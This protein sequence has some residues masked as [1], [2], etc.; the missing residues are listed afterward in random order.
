MRRD[1]DSDI[2]SRVRDLVIEY[3]KKKY[4]EDS[5]CCILT[6]G[7]QQPKAAIRNA[8][9]LLGSEKYDDKTRYADL[10][11]KIAKDVPKTVGMTFDKPIS[12]ETKETCFEMLKRTYGENA[13][14]NTILDYAKDMELRIQN[15]GMHA[16]GVIISDGNPVS[17]YVPLM[18]NTKKQRWV[19]QCDMV[20]SEEKG[21][22]KMD[23]LGLKNL[24]IITDTLRYI[25][26]DYGYSLDPLKIPITDKKTFDL[27]SSGITNGVFQFES[28][29]MKE[30]LKQFRPDCIEDLILLVAAYRPGPMQYLSKIIKVK[31]G[32]EKINYLT[33]ELKPILDKTYGSIIYQEQ[34]MQIFQ[35]LAGYSLGQADLV[36]R[37]MSKKKFK[38]LEKERASFINGDPERKIKGCKANG[39][40]EEIA[41]SLFDEMIEFAK[42]AFNKSHAA[43]YAFVAYITAYFKAN[44]PC[45]YL[46]ADMNW[47]NIDKIPG[48]MMDC[49]KF[50]IEVLPPNINESVEDFSIHNNSILFGLKAV[51][52]V[53]NSSADIIRVRKEHGKFTS[54]KEFI[55]VTNCN[56]EVLESLI[57]AGAFDIF[58]SNRYAM[59]KII[60]A[61]KKQTKTIKE[62]TELLEELK[63]ELA[64]VSTEKDRKKI[65]TREK[66]AEKSL[67]AA[68]DA[69]IST[70]VPTLMENQKER[71]KRE[72]ELIGVYVSAHPLD[73][74]ASPTTLKCTPI[75]ELTAGKKKHI[76]GLVTNLSI[77]PR[78]SDGAPMA[79]FDLEDQT[80]TIPVTCFTKAYANFGEYVQE[81]AVIKINGTCIEEESFR[82]DEDE[83]VMKFNVESI[84]DVKPIEKTVCIYV[85]DMIDWTE[86]TS[87][88]VEKYATPEGL[89]VVVYDKMLSEFR[90]T[91]LHV[92]HEILSNKVGISAKMI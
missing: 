30:M 44:Y 65:L 6:K 10:G 56:K 60:E 67:A 32:K 28:G 37:A 39:I 13:T 63:V 16:A 31:Q 68:E 64:K 33:P 69:Y 4:G 75:E 48:L 70:Q 61:T 46:C 45:E 36:R 89:V 83:M 9:R 71:L 1:I 25:K 66:N 79:F 20:Q 8:A 80:G 53:G 82:D 90:K 88:L 26:K 74:Y 81:D 92:T 22:L 34:V 85:N 58:G 50:N 12:D 17:D 27:L 43:A 41:N 78:K 77:R 87:K 76:F 29:G 7:A 73:E 55:R 59:T 18:F 23:F 14:A 51:K 11:D 52:N 40:S 72:K 84:E 47:S 15:V 38:V 42:Y 3:V 62:K 19:A 2:A 21:L 86:N 57:A 49:K 5:V 91:N 35:D 54:L 24:D